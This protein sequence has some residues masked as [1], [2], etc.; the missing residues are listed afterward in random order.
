MKYVTVAWHPHVSIESI[1]EES[2]GVHAPRVCGLWGPMSAR[3]GVYRFLRIAITSMNLSTKS[4]SLVAELIATRWIPV[5]FV[6]AISCSLGIGFR[7][8]V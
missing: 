5:N 7:I 8:L 6:L 4:T 2:S 1:L 3:S